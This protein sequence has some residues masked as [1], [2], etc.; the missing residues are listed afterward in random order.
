MQGDDAIK[1]EDSQDSKSI[2]RSKASARDA[3]P[4]GFPQLKLVA[5]AA[6]AASC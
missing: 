1:A 6:H 5:A 3:E 4:P 2:K